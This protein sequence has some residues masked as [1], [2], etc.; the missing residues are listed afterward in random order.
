M[1]ITTLKEFFTL[2]EQSRDTRK[3]IVLS[4]MSGKNVPPDLT[5][6]LKEYLKSLE[7]ITSNHNASLILEGNKKIDVDMTYEIEELKK[8]ILFIEKGDKEFIK[9][10][11]KIHPEYR[12]EVDEALQKLSVKKFKNFIT[13]RDGTIN[14]YC[15]RYPTSVQS[16]YNSVFLSL[17]VKK[18]TDHALVLTSAPLSNPGII[19]ISIDPPDTFIYAASKGREFIDAHGKRHDFPISAEKQKM[20]D[21]L[22]TDLSALLK[23]SQYEKYTLIGSG[24]QFKFGQ[25]TIA[26]QDICESI[27]PDESD[28]FLKTIET[29]VSKLDKDGKTFRIEDTG[30]DIE[31]ILTIESSDG[32]GKTKDFDKAD[33]VLYINDELHLGL[34]TGP[35]L[36]CGDTGSDAPMAEAAMSKSS[37]TWVIFVTKDEKLRERVRGICPNSI[38]VTEPDALVS[39]L[40]HLTGVAT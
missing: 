30:K 13:D 35:T 3:D 33:G 20:L 17:F 7:A 11:E 38:F 8:D 9:Y 21:Q 16:V 31:I 12:K 36:V 6:K 26:R 18:C 4:I 24:L 22:N 25:T 39:I 28:A 40:Y 14:N 15:A 23:Q 29:M 37:D 34:D 1:T 2:M 19:D 5:G 27:P 32:S 10:L